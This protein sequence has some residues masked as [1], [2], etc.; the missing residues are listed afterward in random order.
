MFVTPIPFKSFFCS[1]PH[2]FLIYWKNDNLR[3]WTLENHNLIVITIFHILYVHVKIGSNSMLICSVLKWFCVW[4]GSCNITS[5]VMLQLSVMF[6]S[7]KF[8][9]ICPVYLAHFNTDFNSHHCILI[10]YFLSKFKVFFFFSI[11]YD[12]L[13][14]LFG[15]IV[16]QVFLRI[17]L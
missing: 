9:R 10:C 8:R 14:F 4:S 13:F 5:N 11:F 7:Q 17:V 3:E 1:T 15:V 6:N 12:F 2:V 16:Y